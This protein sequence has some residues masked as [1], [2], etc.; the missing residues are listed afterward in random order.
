[1]CRGY[2]IAIQPL[3]RAAQPDDAYMLGQD[4]RTGIRV[5]AAA[6]WVRELHGD[7]VVWITPD[8]V[9]AALANVEAFKRV[10]FTPQA[11]TLSDFLFFLRALSGPTCSTLLY[12]RLRTSSDMVIQSI[13]A[14]GHCLAPRPTG[15]A[16]LAAVAAI[17]AQS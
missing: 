11:Y 15:V 2:A 14:L 5:K 6:V 13:P 7:M 8:E 4:S 3:E 16:M 9:A 17:K 10:H 1:L 12:A